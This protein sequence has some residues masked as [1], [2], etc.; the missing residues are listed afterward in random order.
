MKATAGNFLKDELD[1]KLPEK[2]A[3]QG[4]HFIFRSKRELSSYIEKNKLYFVI[5][6]FN[7]SLKKKC[8]F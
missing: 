8:D 2:M 4:K 6:D 3:E 1:K 5:N 7:F